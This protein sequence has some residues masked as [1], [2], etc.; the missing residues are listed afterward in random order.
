MRMPP[1]LREREFHGVDQVVCAP[2]HC[3]VY[4]GTFAHGNL[5][6][7]P[8]RRLHFHGVRD[9]A[10]D[11]GDRGEPLRLRF[12]SGRGA[13]RYD[14]DA[15]TLACTGPE[16]APDARFTAVAGETRRRHPD[17]GYRVVRSWEDVDLPRS[18][19]EALG[20]FDEDADYDADE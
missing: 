2:T 4:S 8:V 6:V 19:L 9:A 17:G 15:L 12:A 14:P 5:H 10:Y 16:P 3:K 13:C 11:G 20:E 18:M 7:L 1:S